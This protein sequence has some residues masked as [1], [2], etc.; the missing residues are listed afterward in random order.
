MNQKGNIMNQRG[1]TIII[2]VLVVILTL[3]LIFVFFGKKM[4]QTDFSIDSVLDD[5]SPIKN[6]VSSSGS[7]IETKG[8]ETKGEAQVQNINSDTNKKQAPE[9]V[10]MVGQIR[11]I[12]SANFSNKELELFGETNIIKADGTKIKLSNPILYNFEGTIVL[13]DGKAQ[14]VGTVNKIT[15]ENAEI[16]FKKPMQIKITSNEVN[17]K[18][19]KFGLERSGLTGDVSI[20]SLGITLNKAYMNMKNYIGDIRIKDGNYYFA[21]ECD[22]V[23]IKQDGKEI[24]FK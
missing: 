23:T 13:E 1:N 3:L 21:G 16:E 17:I 5:N 20:N 12:K 15:A 18:K 4:G 11:G 8:E 19:V 2:V 6:L 22:L 24:S 10:K 14:I 9:K 7:S